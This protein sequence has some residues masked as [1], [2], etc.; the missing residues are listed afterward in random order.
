MARSRHV[1]SAARGPP[2]IPS[3]E[4]RGF[5]ADSG[6]VGSFRSAQHLK[7]FDRTEFMT[8]IFMS[9]QLQD[10]DRVE[11]DQPTA[12]PSPEQDRAAGVKPCG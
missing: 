9:H 6:K 1:D 11:P 12:I 3:V 2:Y 7:C 8:R 5:T 10:H 4:S